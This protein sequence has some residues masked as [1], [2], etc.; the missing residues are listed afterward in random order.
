MKRKNDEQSSQEPASQ[1]R[2]APFG[3]E[4]SIPP[5]AARARHEGERGDGEALRTRQEETRRDDQEEIEPRPLYWEFFICF[6]LC[7]KEKAPAGTWAL[8]WRVGHALVVG[9]SVK[10]LPPYD[11]RMVRSSMAIRTCLRRLCLCAYLPKEEP[12]DGFS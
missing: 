1:E 2:A 5:R 9:V 6:R 7:G 10:T 3:G 4:A 12:N 11:N 8:Q